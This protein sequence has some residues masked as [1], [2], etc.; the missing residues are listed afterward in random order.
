MLHLPLNHSQ[1]SPMQAAVHAA[2]LPY[3][4]LSPARGPRDD[5][6]YKRQQHRDGE[7]HRGSPIT[8]RS[9]LGGCESL[10]GGAQLEPSMLSPCCWR[11]RGWDMEPCASASL[12]AAST[13]AARSILGTA[14]MSIRACK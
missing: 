11:E 13:A 5:Q 10:G 2:E 6:P 4:V 1:A 9:S 12:T 14:A 7:P 3:F 8:E